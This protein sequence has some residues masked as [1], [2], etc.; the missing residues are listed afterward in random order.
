[1]FK[2]RLSSLVIFREILSDPIV[3]SLYDY[4]DALDKAPNT[5]CSAYCEFVSKLYEH[6]KGLLDTYL[7]NLI[8]NNENVYVKLVGE[9][10]A[11]EKFMAEALE[12]ELALLNELAMLSPE[13]LKK[14]LAFDGFLP[15]FSSGKAEIKHIP[16]SSHRQAAKACLIR[17]GGGKFR[18]TFAD[19]RGKLRIRLAPA[20]EIVKN[21]AL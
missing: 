12:H 14:P 9:G 20:A 15:A 16:V 2:E 7:Q 5:A 21:F 18:R 11:P 17:H 1:L 3:R 10:K 6:G 19:K 4:L 8:F 13:E